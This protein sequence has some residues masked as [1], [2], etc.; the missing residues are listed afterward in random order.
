M[1]DHGNLKDFFEDSRKLIR[2]W[3]DAK[4][5]IY[6]LRMVKVVSAIGGNLVWMIILLF[7]ASLFIIF[8]GVTTGYWLSEIL[9]SYVKGFGIVTL[10]I[11][12]LMILLVIFRKALFINPVIKILIRQVMKEEKE[13]DE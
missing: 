9:G 13:E 3:I 2:D 6:K 10:F 4:L 1:S 7:L 12:L 11:L 5:K 8:A